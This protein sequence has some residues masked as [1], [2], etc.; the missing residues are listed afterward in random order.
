MKN[1]FKYLLIAL[2]GSFFITSCDNEADRNWATPEPTFKLHDT[3][4]GVVALYETMQN[5]PFILTWDKPANVSG[6]YKVVISATEDFASK[7][8][9]GSSNT[10]TLKTTVGELNA[11]ML[12]AGYVP[13]TSKVV[14]LRV[15]NGTEVSNALSFL[16]TPYPTKSPEITNPTANA[17]FVMDINTPTDVAVQ[18]QWNDPYEITTIPVNYNVELAAKGSSDF[19]TLGTVANSKYLDVTHFDLNLAVLSAGIAADTVGE[20]DLRVT[21]VREFIAGDARQYPSKIVTIKV[22]PFLVEYPEFYLVGNASAAEWNPSAAPHLYKHDDVSEIY[23]YLQPGSFRF[24]GQADWNPLNYSI[25]VPETNATYR[26]FKSVSSNVAFDN[27]ENMKF[28]DPAGIY[29]VVINAN[30][31]IKSLTVTPT[32]SVWDIPN[33]YLVGS[34][35]GWMANTAMPF[36]SLGNGKFEIIRALPDNSAFKFLGQQDW[37]GKEWGN[38]RSE[39]NTGYLGINGDNNNIT[40]NGGGNMYKISVDL[41]MGTYNITPQ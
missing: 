18:I 19:K 8:E 38:I 13:Y 31:G 16:V 27:N 28:T 26:Y 22:K 21:A 35:Q 37:T 20:V 12:Q 25:D 23:T 10:T 6:N 39:G 5:N 14:Y 2:V 3:T 15:E 24:L 32:T 1:I 7:V 40:F 9:L 4:L 30:F 17:S 34:I 41:K 11:A 29:K 36:T 33:L